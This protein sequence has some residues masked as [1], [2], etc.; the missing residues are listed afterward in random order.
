M[1]GDSL[2]T[3]VEIIDRVNQLAKKLNGEDREELYQIKAC[4]CS[5]LIDEDAAIVNGS[6]SSNV[7]GLDLPNGKRTHILLSHLKPTARK[8]AR[9]QGGAAPAVAPLKD[10]LEKALRLAE[11]T[12]QR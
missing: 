11:V 10:K 8:R 2:R 6:R 1:S 9:E 3:L 12:Q 7:V 4:G 5:V